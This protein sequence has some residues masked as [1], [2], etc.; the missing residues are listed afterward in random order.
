MRSF[1]SKPRTSKVELGLIFEFLGSVNPN[2]QICGF[3]E[4]RSL[5]SRLPE[6]RS[7][8][9]WVHRTQIFVFLGSV[10]PDLRVFGLNDFLFSRVN[11]VYLLVT[12][13]VKILHKRNPN[14]QT[15]PEA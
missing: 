7:L 5:S 1:S 4:P 10:N 13:R 3:T 6:P 9:F 8:S 15:K 12:E 14:L 2:I 11:V